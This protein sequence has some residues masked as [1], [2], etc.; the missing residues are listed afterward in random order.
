[1]V[2]RQLRADRRRDD[3]VPIMNKPLTDTEISTIAAKIHGGVPIEPRFLVA[4]VDEFRA[5]RTALA[6]MT[7]SRDH[8]VAAKRVFVAVPNHDPGRQCAPS[9]TTCSSRPRTTGSAP[10]SPGQVMVLAHLLQAP[11]GPMLPAPIAHEPPDL[12]RH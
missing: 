3:P 4:L 12:C 5:T 9:T 10:Q 8:A 1:M 11:D 2:T 7:R 6:E